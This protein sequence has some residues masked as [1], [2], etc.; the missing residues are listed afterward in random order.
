MITG[1]YPRHHGMTT[2]GRTMRGDLPTLPAL[3]AEAGYQTHAV[4]K[5]HLQPILA[6]VS[7]RFPESVPFWQAGLGRDWDGPYFGY[8][9]VDFVIGESLL[10]TEDGHYAKW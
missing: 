10:V 8:R 4:G 5:L 3:L 7:Y 9:G 1:R 6:D 2:N